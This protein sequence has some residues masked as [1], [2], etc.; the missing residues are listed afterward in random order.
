MTDLAGQ[1]PLT[2]EQREYVEAAHRAAGQLQGLVDDLLDLS[3]LEGGTL[4]LREVAFSLP[5]LVGDTVRAFLPRAREKRIELLCEIAP[6]APDAVRG[7]P[8]RLRQVFSLLLDNALKYTREGRVTVALRRSGSSGTTGRVVLSVADTGVGIALE[9]QERIFEPLTQADSS[10][11]RREGGAGLG[12]ALVARLVKMMDGDIRLQSEPGRG[13][14]FRVEIEVL[15]DP[16]GRGPSARDLEVLQGQRVLVL[17][18][19]A[20]SREALGELLSALGVRP[21]LTDDPSVA[22]DA[23][24][25]AAAKGSPFAL[26]VVDPRVRGSIVFRAQRAEDDPLVAATPRV[27]LESPGDPGWGGRTGG[28]PRL[29][30]PLT[31][32]EVVAALSRALEEPPQ[33]SPAPPVS[34]VDPLRVL[35]AEDNRVNAFMASRM[36]ERLGHRAE[37]VG[38]GALAVAAVEQGDFEVVLM[39]LQMP[40]MDGLEATRRIRAS[41]RETGRR[42]RVIAV[43][44]FSAENELERCQAAGMDGLLGK[45]FTLEALASM[46]RSRPGKTTPNEGNRADAPSTPDR[47]VFDLQRLAT[48]LGDDHEAVTELLDSFVRDAPGTLAQLREAVT[49]G[50]AETVERAAHRLKGSLLWITAETAAAQAAT[51]ESQARS[52]DLKALQQPLDALDREV[53]RV[54]E[55]AAHR[56]DSAPS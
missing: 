30:R 50:D 10:T 56:A 33:P 9:D 51:L 41:E 13:S 8:A 7:D 52:G 53:G 19:E 54:L 6:D 3:Q 46:L 36:L 16:A 29:T 32:P 43:T 24:A 22:R 26:M 2:S 40:E 37:V 21:M 15:E 25:Q 39:D 14:T 35:V 31:R 28:S 47:P 42:V 27:L 34:G 12:L 23:L 48:Q 4:P 55:E 5:S 49:A 45:P 18:G 38:N 44:A 17:D 11:T 1:T 20:A